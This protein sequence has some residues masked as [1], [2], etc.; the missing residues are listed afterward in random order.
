MVDDMMNM[1][2]EIRD[3]HLLTLDS[4]TKIAE[5]QVSMSQLSGSQTQ[6]ILN[7]MADIRQRTAQMKEAL[8]KAPKQ[9][10]SFF[11]EKSMSSPTQPAVPAIITQLQQLEAAESAEIQSVLSYVAG[12]PAL[13][14]SAINQAIAGGA[15]AAQLAPLSQLASQMRTDTAAMQAALAAAPTAPPP[16]GS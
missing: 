4:L 9:P 7:V 10:H 13:I 15:T 1:L 6:A 16:A 5:A 3:L 2:V 14:T 11:Q 12:V 8:S